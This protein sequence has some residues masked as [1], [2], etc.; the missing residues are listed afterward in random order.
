MRKI[1]GCVAGAL[2]ALAWSFPAFG[3]SAPIK[4]LSGASTNAT[5]VMTGNASLKTLA[6]GNSTATVYFLKL[7]DKATIPVCGTDVPKLTIPLPANQTTPIDFGNGAIFPQ[8]LG[9]CLT[10]AIAD[11]D[12]TAAAAGVAINFGISG[13]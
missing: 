13:R 4:F 12:T 5:L 2:I 10:G 6:G 8:G 1:I 9:F 11:N 3:Q 7:Y